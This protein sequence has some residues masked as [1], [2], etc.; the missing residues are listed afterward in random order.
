MNKDAKAR[1]RERAER[2]ATILDNYRSQVG[3][4]DDRVC[5]VDLLADVLHF[6]N[7]RSGLDFDEA[8]GAAYVHFMAERDGEL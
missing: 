4:D 7:H 1:N 2:A 8:F 5:L 3:G 6:C